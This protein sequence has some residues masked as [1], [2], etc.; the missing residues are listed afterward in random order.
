MFIV[1]LMNLIIFLNLISAILFTTYYNYEADQLALF[2]GDLL[3]I[4]PAYKYSKTYGALVC[5]SYPINIII[6]P[7]TFIFM[8]SKNEDFLMQLNS[9]LCNL[10]FLPLAF[11]ISI[12]FICGNL[13]MLPFAYIFTVVHKFKILVSDHRISK[14]SRLF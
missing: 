9:V 13:I 2:Y 12:F 10:C 8:Y 7:F 3:K 6:F 4:V 14:Y 5:C 1:L 11:V